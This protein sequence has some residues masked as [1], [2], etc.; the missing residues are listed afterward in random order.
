MNLEPIF[1]GAGSAKLEAEK[2]DI[3]NVGKLSEIRKE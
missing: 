2:K 3:D 1:V